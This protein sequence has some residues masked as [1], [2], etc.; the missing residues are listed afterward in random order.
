MESL[1]E[2]SLA[3]SARVA[4]VRERIEAACAR[5]GRTVEEV[6]LVA[7]SKTRTPEEIVA[8]LQAGVHCFA[9]NRPE[10][11]PD[12][13]NAVALLACEHSLP[14]PCWHMIGHIQSR[15]ARLVV[16]PYQLIHS[17]DS[18]HLAQRLDRLAAE[19]GITINALL[20]I[21]TSREVSKFGFPAPGPDGTPDSGFLVDLE[22]MLQMANLKLL[23]LMTV[24]PI[25]ED[26]EDAR[27]YFRRLC[28]LRERLRQRFP[29]VEWQHL[30]MG[31]TDDYEIAI[32]EGSTLVRIGRAIFGERYS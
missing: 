5:V 12:K 17:L 16:G 25:V 27:P 20:E 18:L 29:Q 32:E 11:A 14:Q 13:I 24:A 6:S 3:I 10:E 28:L 26:A 7:A 2:A 23:G 21:N 15:K 4:Q 30:S 9:E 8:A 22:P 1:W 19:R 31:M